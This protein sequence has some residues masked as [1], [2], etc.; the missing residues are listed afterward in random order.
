LN[1]K[2]EVLKYLTPFKYFE[3]RNLMYDAGFEGVFV[4]LTVIFISA[5]LIVTYVSFSK[6]DLKI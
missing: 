2:L 3:A 1:E 4:T 6:K 5:L